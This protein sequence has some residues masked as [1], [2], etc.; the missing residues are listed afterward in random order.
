MQK[1]KFVYQFLFK[2]DC[3]YILVTPWNHAPHLNMQKVY[4]IVKICFTEFVFLYIN[5]VIYYLYK[6]LKIIKINLR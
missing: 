3:D 4:K 5:C 6:K 2:H 1:S